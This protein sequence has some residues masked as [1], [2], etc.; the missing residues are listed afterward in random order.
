MKIV[1]LLNYSIN[2][3]DGVTKKINTQITE[4]KENGHEVIAVNM[5]EVVKDP[6]VDARKYYCG[7]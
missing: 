1:Y 3:E 7:N 4:W 6:K 2:K 5:F